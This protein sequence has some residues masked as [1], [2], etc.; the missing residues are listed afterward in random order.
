MDL[1][2]A[3][4]GMRSSSQGLKFQLADF[5]NSARS[6]CF[7][8]RIFLDEAETPACLV[9][10]LEMLAIFEGSTEDLACSRNWFGLDVS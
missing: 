3:N 7:L 6:G 4:F 8:E 1:E 10:V 9:V 2:L 5:E